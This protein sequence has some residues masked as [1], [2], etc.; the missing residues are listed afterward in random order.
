MRIGAPSPSAGRKYTPVWTKLGR[1]A[2]GRLAVQPLRHLALFL[3]LRP[4]PRIRI[5]L[6]L[7]HS[8]QRC[9]INVEPLHHLM[10]MRCLPFRTAR[11]PPIHAALPVAALM[12]CATI[13]HRQGSDGRAVQ[14]IG[15]H[16]DLRVAA[17][18][19]ARAAARCLAGGAYARKVAPIMGVACLT[20]SGS[21]P[22]SLRRSGNNWDVRWLH[23]RGTRSIAVQSYLRGNAPQLTWRASRQFVDRSTFAQSRRQL[24][25]KR[26]RKFDACS[27]IICSSQ[28]AAELLA[29]IAEK[30]FRWRKSPRNG[31]L[32]HADNCRLTW[33]KANCGQLAWINHWEHTT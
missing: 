17:S 7:A 9:N 20:N 29:Q 18:Q 31:M 32:P 5:G 11:H 26:L 15:I 25:R 1:L 12:S 24:W 14:A 27:T 33:I 21:M 22:N 13:T 23:D 16:A 8:C 3:H 10:H 28:L 6:A 30:R 19:I 2:R 4:G